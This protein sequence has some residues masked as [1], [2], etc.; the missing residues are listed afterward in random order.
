MV[1]FEKVGVSV[2]ALVMVGVAAPVPPFLVQRR[3]AML[4][5]GSLS[6][7]PVGALELVGRVID[8]S[9]PA[10]AV[11]ATLVAETV[12][13]VHAPQL[14]SSLDSVMVPVPAADALS[15]QTRMYTIWAV[16]KVYERV[17]VKVE[18]VASDVDRT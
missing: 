8:L 17:A 14:L 9:G 13:A 16:V 6:L 12:T 3:E 5:P 18:E 1:R 4:P 2:V 15:A 10:E 7:V 11:G